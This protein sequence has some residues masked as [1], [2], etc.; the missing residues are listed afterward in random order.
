MVRP[1]SVQRGNASE[2]PGESKSR[3]PLA[4][5]TAAS[6]VA[7]EKFKPHMPVSKIPGW[8]M[9]DE[10]KQ[11]DGF[12]DELNEFSRQRQSVTSTFLEKEWHQSVAAYNAN[13]TSS[14]FAA[15]RIAA[16]EYGLAFRQLLPGNFA[17]LVDHARG[18]VIRERIVPFVR[19]ILERGLARAKEQLH[20][21]IAEESA[22]HKEL[23]HESFTH[24]GIV[25]AARTPVQE[26]ERLLSLLTGGRLDLIEPRT[27]LFPYLRGHAAKQ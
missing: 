11:L 8:V 14:A 24:S 26:I 12:E 4:T 21:V 6:I 19:P 1:G 25:E 3:E 13:P 10:I 27:V 5:T 22:R 7:A 16:V 17:D 9:P 20:S 18:R 2:T 23:T 15:C